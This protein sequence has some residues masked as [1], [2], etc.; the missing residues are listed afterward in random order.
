MKWAIIY[1]LY[2][3]TD[4]YFQFLTEVFIF[5]NQQ[6][7]HGKICPIIISLMS[8]MKN[9]I[10]WLRQISAVTPVFW[11]WPNGRVSLKYR[12]NLALRSGTFPYDILIVFI[13]HFAHDFAALPVLW[14]SLCRRE[15]K[16]EWRFW[17]KRLTSLSLFL[18]SRARCCNSPPMKFFI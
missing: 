1:V 13:W 17:G 14:K 8:A 5:L 2:V 6:S 12:W 15:R 9:K 18:F 4:F 7:V 16:S 10:I 3:K 11:K